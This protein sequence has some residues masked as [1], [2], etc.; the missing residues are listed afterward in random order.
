MVFWVG[1]VKITDL[2]L[3]V[4][5]VIKTVIEIYIDF[6]QFFANTKITKLGVSSERVRKL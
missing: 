3:R 2:V 5:F 4:S 6:K 1:L